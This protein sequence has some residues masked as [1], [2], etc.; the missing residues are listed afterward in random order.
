MAEPT[1]DELKEYLDD[2]HTQIDAASEFAISRSRVQRILK[3]G[4]DH[5][6]P[7]ERAVDRALAKW[8]E[9]DE[10][11]RLRAELL[12]GL[13]VIADAGRRSATGVAMASGVAAITKLEE[14]L[15]RRGQ[16]AAVADLKELLL[17][18]D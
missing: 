11:G 10:E 7:T 3:A 8:A 9:D 2:G 15:A 1:Y 16:S 18:D 6:G 13:A 12:R 5:R 17:G 14:L 4:E